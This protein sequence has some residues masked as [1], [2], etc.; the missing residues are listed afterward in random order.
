MERA[1]TPERAAFFR[2]AETALDAL[3]ARDFAAAARAAGELLPKHRGDGP[4]LLTLSR[5]SAAL[6]NDGADFDP[7]WVPPGK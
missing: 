7:V 4:L 3:E 2:A 6:M 5:A 1:S